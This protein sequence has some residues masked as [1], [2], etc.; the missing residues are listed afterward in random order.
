MLVKELYTDGGL[1][2]K[3]NPC[4]LGCTWAWCHVTDD[5]IVNHDSGFIEP[6]EVGQT[7]LTNNYAELTAMIRGLDALPNGWDGR[8][9]TDSIVTLYRVAQP[10]K[11]SFTGISDDQR[12]KLIA[13]KERLGSFVINLVK[14]H[15]TKK[16]R[17]HGV[18]KDGRAIS[19]WNVWCDEACVTERENF[20]KD[21]AIFQQH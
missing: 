1:G 15:P 11:A 16:D 5:A 20:K 7:A 19:K 10:R 17:R 14:G 8:V 13:V 21:L 6:W 9:F 3:N 12:A 4:I 2:G 18:R